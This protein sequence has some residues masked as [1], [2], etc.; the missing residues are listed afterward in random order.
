MIQ[1]VILRAHLP[2]GIQPV[3]IFVGSTGGEGPLCTSE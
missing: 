1:Q 2:T 3:A